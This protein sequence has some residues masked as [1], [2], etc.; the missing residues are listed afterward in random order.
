M[1]IYINIYSQKG[2]TK[3]GDLLAI[4]DVVSTGK[5]CNQAE[6]LWHYWCNRSLQGKDERLM[7]SSI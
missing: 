6:R 1:Y 5:E 4:R 3:T 7:C 2:S